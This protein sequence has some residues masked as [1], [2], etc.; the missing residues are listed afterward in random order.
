MIELLH[1]YYQSNNNPWFRYILCVV[2]GIQLGVDQSR[3]SVLVRFYPKFPL[4]MLIIQFNLWSHRTIWS[5]EKNPFVRAIWCE[6][7]DWQTTTQGDGNSIKKTICG[8]FFLYIIT[9]FSR[10]FIVLV[11]F[12]LQNILIHRKK[13]FLLINES[14]DKK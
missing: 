7:Y 5:H 8:A 1:S 11:L 13:Q 10:H 9:S 2:V 6:L 4:D 14:S 12:L 3:I